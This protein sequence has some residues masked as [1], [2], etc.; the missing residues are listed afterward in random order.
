MRGTFLAVRITPAYGE[1]APIS[2]DGDR[3]D[4][5]EPVARQR[6]R[7][8]SLLASLDD[9][10]WATPSRCAGWSVQDVVLHLITVNNFWESSV[11]AG[12]AG[13]PTQVLA[14]F[15][16]AAHPSLLIASMRTLSPA[17]VLERFSRSND[18]LLDALAEVHGD[19]WDAIGE[20]PAGHV[21]LRLLAQHALWDSWVHERDVALPLGM[22]PP[23]EV[24]EVQS[25]LRYAAAIGPLLMRDAP[26]PVRGTFAVETTSPAYSFTLTIDGD[27]LVAHGA[28]PASAPCLRGDAATL[29]DVLSIRV[30]LP[31]DA[32]AEWRALVR[33]LATVFDQ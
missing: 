10:Q 26:E 20:S 25:C 29:V 33:A 12:L 28:P 9:R 18:G 16:P 4:Q 8:R 3:G 2:F 27:V 22:T 30:P 14:N 17:E 31:D 1:A 15:D 32:P 19:G 21:S 23:V 11:R 24:D 13:T 6:R 7:F 5:A